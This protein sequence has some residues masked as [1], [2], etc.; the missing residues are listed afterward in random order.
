[1]AETER[2]GGSYLRCHEAG[3]PVVGIC[4]GFQ[5][6]GQELSDPFGVEN[7]GCMRGM[8]L[9]NTKTVFEK[10]RPGQGLGGVSSG[11]K[12]FFRNCRALLWK[13]MRFIWG[14]LKTLAAVSP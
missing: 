4:G 8:G 9:L 13:V 3:T 6:L 12:G 10:V 2:P 14:S 7:G 1:M 5:M 11:Q